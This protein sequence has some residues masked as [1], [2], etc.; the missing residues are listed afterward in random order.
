MKYVRTFS[1]ALALCAASTLLYADADVED[2]ARRIPLHPKVAQECS[3]CHVAFWPNFL[4]TSSWKQVLS[5]LDKHYGADASL[6]A[7]DHQVIFDWFLANSQ[8]LGEAPPGNRITKA[9]WFTR[10]HGTRHI[11]AD[12]WSRQS[13]KSPA[14]CQACH[15]DAAKGDFNEH[16]IRIPG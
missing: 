13:V 11:R 2:S 12:V 10:K 14:N 7:A 16:K 9:F 1:M 4:P 8:E 6:P 15:I 3:A 5:T